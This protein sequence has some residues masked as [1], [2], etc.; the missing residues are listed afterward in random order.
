MISLI[1]NIIR[2]GRVNEE[3]GVGGALD[4]AITPNGGSRLA[5]STDTDDY[6]PKTNFYFPVVLFGSPA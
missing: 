2:S 6:Y 1:I 4:R 3:E 5:A